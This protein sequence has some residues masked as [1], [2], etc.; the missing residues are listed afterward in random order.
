MSPSLADSLI[1]AGHDAMHARDVGLKS[2]PDVEILAAASAQ[3]R[4]LITQ[5]TDFGSLIALTAAT[6]PSVVLFRG[7]VTRRPE[8]QASLLLANL[9]QLLED[10]EAGAIVVIGDDRLRVRRLPIE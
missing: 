1:A 9:E 5:D 2:A 7:H 8:G 6:L 10:L 4:V 3:G